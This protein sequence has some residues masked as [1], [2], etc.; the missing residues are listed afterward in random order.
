MRAS[1]RTV[2]G[3]C[4]ISLMI[5]SSHSAAQTLQALKTTPSTTPGSA[6]VDIFVDGNVKN[7]IAQSTSGANTIQGSLGARYRGDTYL[8]TA[9]INLGGTLDTVTTNYGLSILA[10]A[11]GRALNAALLEIRRPRAFRRADDKQCNGDPTQV[12]CNFGWRAYATLT[13]ARWATQ[14]DTSGKV[15]GVADVPA[16]GLGGGMSYTF[17]SGTVDTNNVGVVLDAGYALRAISGDLLAQDT[18]RSR[19][20]HTEATVFTGL[21]MGL[22]LQYNAIK[23]GVTYYLLNGSVGGLSRGQVVA[24]ASI[25]ADLV[26]GLL[27]HAPKKS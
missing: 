20:L 19:L 2:T 13:T 23:A 8:V 4:A 16:L 3:I 24:G 15:L 26:S 6:Y 5:G 17:F 27:T 10:P 9:S 18:L 21:E 7:V 22:S 11:T 1:L 12:H 25:Q 14:V